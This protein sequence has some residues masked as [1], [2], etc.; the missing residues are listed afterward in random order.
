VQLA[1]IL[2]AYKALP[3]AQQKLVAKDAMAATKHMRF[4]PLPGPQTDAYLSKADVL[5]YGGQAGGGK[6]FLLMGLGSQ[7]H[8]RSIIFRREAG[9]TDG[10]EEAGKQIIG[11]DAS[12]NG[13]DLEW[14]FPDGRSV[15]LAGIKE[16]G[17][18]NKHAG[19][20][21]DFLGFDEAGE[22]L[23]EQVASLLAWNRG[24]EGQRC[25]I[26]LASNPPRTAE[27]AWMIEWFAPWLD[28]N[29]HSRALPSEL[30]Y[31]AMVNGKP[32]W[33]EGPGDV[34]ID[35]EL[36]RP[37]SFTF[38]PASLADNPYRDTPEYR[39]K[40]NSLPEP[41]RSQL[42]KGIFALGGED[43]P[44][45][46]IP[47]D[48]VLQ[49]IAR[50][51]PKPPHGVPMCSI[52][53]DV[54]QGGADQTVLAIRHDGWYAPLLVVPGAQTPGGTDVAG[55][56]ISKRRDEATV[57]IDIGGGWGGDAYAHLRGN[58]VE[59]SF[60]Y[61]GV[62][63]TAARTHDKQLKLFNVRSQA[64]WQFREA[65][66]PDQVGGSSI[67]L[68]NDKE[69]IADLCAPKFNV[70]RMGHVRAV[71]VEAKEDVVKRLGRSTDKGDAVVM[72][73]HSGAKAITHA[74]QWSKEQGR[75]RRSIE[76]D[77]GPRRKHG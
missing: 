14:S 42:L 76:V 39:A 29:F 74:G 67:A 5:L 25:R 36:Y 70:V 3:E 28:E 64:Y 26:V 17:D 2:Q 16:P 15:K 30:R 38:I 34:E 32:V 53:A 60:G 66:N 62:K 40:L 57:V 44:W 72:A 22:F 11:T 52:G 68:P 23:V 37:L 59:N 18:W 56:V 8:R 77:L 71:K 69:L 35:G 19:R 6:S 4:V 73:W 10:L 13:S 27:G 47:T 55:L 50:W 41:L 9:Q 45:Q 51:K 33:Q 54:A 21:R 61:M 24:P 1:E 49:A 7:E 75:G 20:E 48:W 65:L 31:A 43:D 12:F 58:G 63:P 46:V